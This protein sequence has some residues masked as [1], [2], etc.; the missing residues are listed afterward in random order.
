VP[1]C[2]S[3]K[4]ILLVLLRFKQCAPSRSIRPIHA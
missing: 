4:F 1:N 3:E 2:C